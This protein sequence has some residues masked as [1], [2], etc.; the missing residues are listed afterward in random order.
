MSK[1]AT[2]VDQSIGRVYCSL[3]ELVRKLSE[4]CEKDDKFKIAVDKNFVL[5]MKVGNLT[6]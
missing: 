4:M 2:A 1:Q 3:I 6:I 5:V